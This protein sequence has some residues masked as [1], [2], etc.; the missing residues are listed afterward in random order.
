MNIAFMVG[1]LTSMVTT[2]YRRRSADGEETRGRA[3]ERGR[4]SGLEMAS[5]SDEFQ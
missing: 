5:G 2:S 3:F 4:N 1:E